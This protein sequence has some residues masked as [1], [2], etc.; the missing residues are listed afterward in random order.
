MTKIIDPNNL[1]IEDMN[2][3]AEFF[4]SEPQKAHSVWI[5]YI[6]YPLDEARKIEFTTNVVKRERKNGKPGL[7]YEFY[8]Y[9]QRIGSGSHGTVYEI[10]G[11]LSLD[12]GNY[13]FKP[14]GHNNKTRVVKR[15]KEMSG[16]SG[17]ENQASIQV[18]YELSQHIPYLSMKPPVFHNRNA[19]LVM[20]KLRGRSLESILAD[21]L[22]GSNVLTFKDRV[23]LSVALLRVL[24]TDISD[25]KII[26]RDLSLVNILVDFSDS[27]TAYIIDLGLGTSADKPDKRFCGT[28]A[29]TAP[30]LF[31]GGHVSVK[32][33]VYS[34][35]RVLALVWRVSAE[36][37]LT[38]DEYAI[39]SLNVSLDS[40]FSDIKVSEGNKA[41]IK[42]T[43]SKMMLSNWEARYSVEEAIQGFE[44]IDTQDRPTPAILAG[45]TEKSRYNVHRF[46]QVHPMSNEGGVTTE[47]KRQEC[48]CAIM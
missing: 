38:L 2:L 15:V 35:G 5:P 1:S 16:L 26:H 39:N 19:W 47:R 7:R 25:R 3:L 42:D 4:N 36:I 10:A 33:D 48:N 18:E 13:C 30:E 40:L 9:F 28:P 22:D 17:D 29:F 20:R 43:L 44:K 34:M 23:E 24:K 11:S 8:S 46:L 37:S 41:L 21:D 27:T 31:Y 14:A 32:S 6:E 45:G 12:A